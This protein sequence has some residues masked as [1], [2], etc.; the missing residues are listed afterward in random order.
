MLYEVITL[1]VKA[2]TANIPVLCGFSAATS[3]GIAYADKNNLT[4]VGRLRDDSF[5]IYANGWRIHTN[6]NA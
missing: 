5:N 6:S 4:L 2:S 3:S 1:A